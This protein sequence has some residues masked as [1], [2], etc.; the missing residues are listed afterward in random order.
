MIGLRDWGAMLGRTQPDS[1][2]L[3]PAI[4]NTHPEARLRFGLGLCVLFLI[5]DG[6]D[7]V[8][9]HQPVLGL[10]SHWAGASPKA[11]TYRLPAAQTA[12]VRTGCMAAVNTL[13]TA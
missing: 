9:L 4:V 5:A 6:S 7:S 2:R 1:P 10:N 8:V 12:A 13:K 3:F 11:A